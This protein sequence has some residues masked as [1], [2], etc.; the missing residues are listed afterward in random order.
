MIWIGLW[1]RGDW[2]ESSA[3]DNGS[4]LWI[5]E[6]DPGTEVLGLKDWGRG[7]LLNFEKPALALGRAAAST[8]L[9]RPGVSSL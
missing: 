2:K 5:K 4:T 6:G 3:M 9:I 1:G 7:L 8:S